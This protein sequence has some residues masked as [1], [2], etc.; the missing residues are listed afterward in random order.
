MPTNPAIISTRVDPTTRKLL[1]L[2]A[3]EIGSTVSTVLR[4]ALSCLQ[5]RDGTRAAQSLGVVGVPKL[6]DLL[7]LPPSATPEQ[8]IAAV[9]AILA[10]D[11]GTAPAVPAGTDTPGKTGQ[12]AAKPITARARASHERWLKLNPGARRRTKAK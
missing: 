2:R 5:L 10:A 7:G 8:I 6:C 4:T 12:S 11:P 9:Q 1:E 3:R